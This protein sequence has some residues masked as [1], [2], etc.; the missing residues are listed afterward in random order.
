VEP[1]AYLVTEVYGR[2]PLWEYSGARHYLIADVAVG[3]VVAAIVFAARSSRSPRPPRDGAHPSLAAW[4]CTAVLA[5]VPIVLTAQHAAG[6]GAAHARY[7]LPI[8]PIV[9]AATALVTTR[10]NRWFA[11]VVV[12]AF[13]IAQITRIRAAGNVHDAALTPPQLR[14]PVVGQPFLALTVA[15]AIVGAVVLLGSLVRAAKEPAATQR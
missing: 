1:F 11:V 7:L 10:I 6:G 12:G 13:A 14:D 15:V 9:A 3:V 8:L 2:S 5:L 4:I